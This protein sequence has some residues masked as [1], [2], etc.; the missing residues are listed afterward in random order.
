MPGAILPALAKAGT[1]RNQCGQCLE[2][3]AKLLP[4]AHKNTAISDVVT[5]EPLAV[6]GLCLLIG[7]TQYENTISELGALLWSLGTQKL[8]PTRTIASVSINSHALP[9]HISGFSHF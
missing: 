5:C 6:Y 1:W 8:L 2:C 7:I 4:S 3:G 9:V